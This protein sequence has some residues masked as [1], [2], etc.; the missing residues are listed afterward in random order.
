[1][2]GRRPRSAAEDVLDTI[3]AALDGKPN[4]FPFETELPAPV[5]PNRA[6][7]CYRCG[8]SEGVSEDVCPGCRAYVLG[9]TDVDPAEATRSVLATWTTEQ[10]SDTVRDDR[11]PT[12]QCQHA[13]CRRRVVGNP[14]CDRHRVVVVPPDV[15]EPWSWSY[16]P[17]TDTWTLHMLGLAAM[18]VPAEWLADPG[19][20]A[21]VSAMLD[22]LRVSRPRP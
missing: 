21:H 16:E 17:S 4:P 10:D 6:G 3:D 2:T 1:M 22:R 9:D 15:E 18:A 7:C 13:H 19:A 14:H 12:D 20:M 5:N 8:T 11:W